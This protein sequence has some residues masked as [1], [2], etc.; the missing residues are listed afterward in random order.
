MSSFDFGDHELTTAESGDI[1]CG[2]E[3]VISIDPFTQHNFGK[4]NLDQIDMHESSENDAIYQQL[5]STHYKPTQTAQLGSNDMETHYE[6][7]DQDAVGSSEK[8]SL[9][10]G[11][12]KLTNE[13]SISLDTDLAAICENIQFYMST[14]DAGP[15]VYQTLCTTLNTE[16]E[17]DVENSWK[18]PIRNLARRNV[19]SGYYESLTPLSH[20]DR[21]VAIG[22]A[23][24]IVNDLDLDIAGQGKSLKTCNPTNT[25]N[26][27]NHHDIIDDV[28]ESLSP[29]IEGTR[30]S[31][32]HG[33]DLGHSFMDR[34][35]R[36]S[37][38][39]DY[40]SI[41]SSTSGNEDAE[42]SK[43]SSTVLYPES[44]DRQFWIPSWQID[45]NKP[46]NQTTSRTSEVSMGDS[47]DCN[48][49]LSLISSTGSESSMM[50]ETDRQGA[51]AHEKNMAK[52]ANRHRRSKSE[53]QGIATQ[54]WPKMHGIAQSMWNIYPQSMSKGERNH[55][56]RPKSIYSKICDYF[57][58]QK[59]TLRTDHENG[60]ESSFVC[61][62]SDCMI[63]SNHYVMQWCSTEMHI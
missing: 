48:S 36:Y 58:N 21:N 13:R 52:V 50:P 59:G 14:K 8:E 62:I 27:G 55:S 43:A 40:E 60:A 22:K 45:K 44:P 56:V 34:A 24:T 53:G 3:S 61:Y 12:G 42:Q 18:S 26:P 32:T 37:I 31:F 57:S 7:W 28:Y 11:H 5:L 4:N 25:M 46:S 1:S 33:W 39:T 10:K 54:T 38:L 15:D 63:C 30:P 2:T 49:Y 29:L 23:E 9:I 41:D 35:P 16:A 17:S 47:T 6:A 19:Y 51:C 20:L